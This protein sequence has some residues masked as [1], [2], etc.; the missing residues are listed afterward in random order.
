MEE[1]H[2]FSDRKEAEKMLLF[3]KD[4]YAAYP[5]MAYFWIHE[6]VPII[7]SKNEK[8]IGYEVGVNYAP[9]D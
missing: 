2:Y 7:N 1:V 3:L 4:E 6:D 9:L 8:M 5:Y